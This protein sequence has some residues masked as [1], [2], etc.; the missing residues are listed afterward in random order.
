V[1][2]ASGTS[3][4]PPDIKRLG[5]GVGGQGNSANFSAKCH[6]GSSNSAF[7]PS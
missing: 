3:T 2:L 4:A 5:N 6:G 7:L 1:F